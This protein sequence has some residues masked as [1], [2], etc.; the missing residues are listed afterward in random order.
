[1]KTLLAAAEMAQVSCGRMDLPSGPRERRFLSAGPRATHRPEET[2]MT[3]SSR[4]SRS[5]ARVRRVHGELS[6]ANRRMFEI[7]TGVSA[8]RPTRPTREAMPHSG[9]HLAL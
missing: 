4:I 9:Q 3:L 7:T 2:E 1:M 6:H 5:A 8:P